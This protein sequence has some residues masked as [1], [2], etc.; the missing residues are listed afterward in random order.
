MADTTAK[1]ILEVRFREKVRG[2]H[3]G[4]VDAF[5][6]QV[7]ATVEELQVRAAAAEA[8]VADLE[9]RVNEGA[10]ADDS[11]RRTLVL[12]QRTADLAV[13]EARA[14]AAKL[15][16]EAEE[17]RDNLLA[18]MADMRSRMVAEV[19]AEV[20]AEQD[21]LFALRSALQA[22]VEALR[23]HFERERERLRI[24]FNDQLRRLDEGE[25]G[26]AA[27]PEM[28]AP[29]PPAATPAPEAAEAGE[30]QAPAAGEEGAAAEEDPFL[31]ELRRAVTDDEPL[32][33]R[34]T[35][36]PD[37]EDDDGFDLF[38]QGGDQA[39]RFGSRRRRRRD[40]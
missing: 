37:D 3:Q 15:V 25:P 6:S 29:A 21:R 1:S 38:A 8:K 12:A 28:E 27:A 7:A 17:Q 32:G 36:P 4:D 2:Y 33:P 10:E 39:G 23:A 19:E 26:V 40:G 11:L 9:S 14:E 35:P 22:D 20:R 31:A 34:E 24:Y 13:Q 5:V 18:Q 30:H 16:G